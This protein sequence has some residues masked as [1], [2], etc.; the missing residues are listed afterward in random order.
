MIKV[1]KAFAK[2]NFCRISVRKNAI[3]ISVD[4]KVVVEIQIVQIGCVLI[5]L[6]VNVLNLIEVDHEIGEGVVG[7]KTVGVDQT[8]VV[9]AKV[10]FVEVWIVAKIEGILI[11]FVL[12]F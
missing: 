3:E 5:E 9:V 12:K 10:N 6:R 1:V 2:S 7:C 4:T 11:F 8:Q